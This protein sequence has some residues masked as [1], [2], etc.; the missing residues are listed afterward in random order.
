M[1]V[2]EVD[3]DERA[4]GLVERD[5]HGRAAALRA[6]RRR[7]DL[8]LD[9]EPGGLEIGHEA[10]DGGA[11]EARPAGDVGTADRAPLAQGVDDA[12]P[13]ALTQ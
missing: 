4:G 13:V 2:T 12:Q 1:A 3:A 8:A 9:D 5:Q 6:A 10:R 7:G 11:A